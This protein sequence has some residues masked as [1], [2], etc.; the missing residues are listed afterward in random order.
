MIDVLDA[1]VYAEALG[2]WLHGGVKMWWGAGEMTQGLKAL[3][4]FPKDTGFIPRTH[5]A[6]CD[7]V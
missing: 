1:F 2:G 7:C 4:V 5:M 6:T 3:S